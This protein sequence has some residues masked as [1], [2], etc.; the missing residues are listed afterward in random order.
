[1]R[2]IH[3]V[4]ISVLWGVTGPDMAGS[5]HDEGPMH[6]VSL[7]LGPVLPVDMHGSSPYMLVCSCELA[8]ATA[9]A[10]VPGSCPAQAGAL[11]DAAW[12]VSAGTTA[13]ATDATAWLGTRV[14]R[15]LSRFMQLPTSQRR[16]KGGCWGMLMRALRSDQ[17]CFVWCPPPTC[18]GSSTMVQP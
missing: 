18:T 7:L 12:Q 10:E 1:M 13:A 16:E 5:G 9:S 8:C 6:H 15:K 17:N 11:H 4:S 3:A 2:A 14:M